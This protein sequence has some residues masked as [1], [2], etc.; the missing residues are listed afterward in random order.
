MKNQCRTLSA[1]LAYA[2]FMVCCL[3]T[4]AQVGNPYE[5]SDSVAAGTSFQITPDGETVVFLAD[6]DLDNIEELY[7][8]PIVGGVPSRLSEEISA[9]GFITNFRISNNSQRLI[10]TA[11]PFSGQSSEEAFTVSIKGGNARKIKLNAANRFEI[12]ADSRKIIYVSDSSSSTQPGL[13]S[14]PIAGGTPTLLDAANQDDLVLLGVSNDSQYSV[15]SRD[16]NLFSIPVN[17]GNA[18]QLDPSFRNNAGAFRF[19]ISANSQRVVYTDDKN[20][21]NSNEL[22]SVSIT[23]DSPTIELNS[24]LGDTGE[25]TDFRISADSSR[26]VY[27]SDQDLDSTFEIYTVAITGG[28]V[29]KLNSD[30]SSPIQIVADFQITADSQRVIYV[31]NQDQNNSFDLYSVPLQGGALVRLN[32]PL[33]RNSSFLDLFQ[34]SADSRRVVYYVNNAINNVVEL[35]SVGV[36]GGRPVKLNPDLVAGG[37]VLATRFQI[38]GD[39]RRVLYQADQDTNDVFELYGV[40]IMGGQSTRINS[41]LPAGSQVNEFLINQRGDFVVYSADQDVFGDLRLYAHQLRERIE[42]VLPP[43]LMLLLS[44]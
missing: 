33:D 44:D 27:Q 10:Y 18:K 9:G 3:S 24:N 25:V 39:S 13:Y 29:L 23:G 36:E 30:F 35:Y 32:S 6:R 14:L 16:S 8:V 42:V 41:R 31:A 11:K 12:T 21:N 4:H 20:D 2:L 22:Y 19:K 28:A 5:I 26:V 7:S 40:P 34:I 15:Y 37:N 17:G 38:S 43:S 1:T